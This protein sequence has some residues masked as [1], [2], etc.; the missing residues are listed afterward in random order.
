MPYF[1]QNLL[2]DLK[3]TFGIQ[4]LPHV[5][6]FLVRLKEKVGTF[7][8][9]HAYIHMFYICHF[10]Y[11]LFLHGVCISPGPEGK[12]WISDYS[13]GHSKNCLFQNLQVTDAT[14]HRNNLLQAGEPS[15]P[16]PT[17]GVHNCRSGQAD[18][19][20]QLGVRRPLLSSS[21]SLWRQNVPLMFM[22][23]LIAL[24]QT[25]SLLSNDTSCC[26]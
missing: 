4:K 7:S 3:I 22:S 12:G 15:L 17:V 21:Q 26:A 2:L 1:V 23:S 18:L 19:C 20:V 14:P 24:L 6:L 10:L 13:L 8:F 25:L 5:L 9:L 16:N 11:S